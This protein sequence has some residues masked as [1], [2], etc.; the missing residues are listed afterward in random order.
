MKQYL[1]FDLF[2]SF[3]HSRTNK[4]VQATKYDWF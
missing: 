2:F 1:L 3:R 4:S